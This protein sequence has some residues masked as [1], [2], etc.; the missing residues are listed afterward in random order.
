VNPA[1]GSGKEQGRDEWC[2]PLWL[3]RLLPRV[4]LDPCSNMRS[5]VQ[6]TWLVQFKNGGNGLEKGEPGTFRVSE[7]T[8]ALTLAA[9]AMV[10]CNPPYVRGQV[11]KWVKHY[12]HTRFIYLLRWDPSTDWFSELLP[13]CTHVWFPNRRINFEP[14]P[15]VKAS[16]NPFPHALYLRD[17]DPAFIRRLNTTGYTLRVDNGKFQSQDVPHG[18]QSGD[19]AD[20]QQAGGGGAAGDGDKGGGFAGVDRGV[21]PRCPD[22]G[23]PECFCVC[24][25]QA[26]SH[27]DSPF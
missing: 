23:K 7:H 11:I 20:G 13:H 12:R 2:T 25:P 15:G 14:P 22:C 16:S 21:E 27:A 17:P 8:K 19:R 18:H 26:A 10:F 9:T 1:G 3:V 5:H 6:A 4:D 24:L